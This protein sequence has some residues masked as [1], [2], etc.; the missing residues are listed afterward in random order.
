MI[1]D[2]FEEFF[3][4][5]WGYEPFPWQSALMRRVA[6]T[7]W[8]EILDVPTSAGKTAAIDIALF[9]LTLE[10]NRPP[11]E[12]KAPVR[13]VFTIDRRLVVDDAY[14]RACDIQE[15][16]A[17]AEPGTILTNVADSLRNISGSAP[18]QVIRLR[19]GVPRER[20]F[21]DNPLQPTIVLSTVDQVGSRLL[22]RG[23]GV[24]QSMRPVHAALMGMDS[25]IILDEAHLSQPFE[26]TLA[27]VKRYQSEAWAEIT[28]GRPTTMI[29]MTATPSEST[30]KLLQAGDWVH[31]VLGPRLTRSKPAKLLS[32][33]GKKEEPESTRQI[34]AKTLIAQAISLMPTNKASSVV[35][36]VVNRV[37]TA[38]QV[39][40]LLSSAKGD[41]D[42]IL[43][44]GRTRPLD[45]D[46]LV[47]KYLDR[48]KAGR[49]EGSNLRSLYVIATQTIE[50]GA[51][52]DF[53][54]LVTESAALDALRQRFGRLNR[55]GKHE[56]ADAVIV[57]VDYGRS[58]N[59]D[60]IYG[61]ALTATWKWM[62]Q[63]AGKKKSI[64][65]G[66]QAMK[67]L[68]QDED[69][70][71]MLTPRKQASVL[72][73]AHI[74]MFVQTNPAPAVVPEIAPYL[75]GPATEA[76]DVQLIWRADLPA[77]PKN[78]SA[79][80]EI[81]SALP[82]ASLEV[83]ALPVRS[84]RAFLAGTEQ[85]DLSD[86]EG[87]EH[88][89]DNNIREICKRYAVLWRGE[90]PE[91]IRDPMKI[92]PGD[93]IMIPATYGGLDEFGWDPESELPAVDI[94]DEA[95]SLQHGKLQL[96]IHADLMSTWF[97]DQE[98]K[99]EAA[100]ILKRSLKR[101]DTEDVDLPELCDSLIEDLLKLPINADIREKLTELKTNR[102]VVP[103]P[104]GILIKKVLQ[105]KARFGHEVLLAD[106]C[107]GVS[108]LSKNFA[109]GCGLPNELVINE[110]L[111]G[112]MHDLGKADPRFQLSLYEANSLVM[113]KANKLLA[114]SINPTDLTTT[115]KYRN[116]SGYPVGARHECYSVA[117]IESN[118]QV[119][120]ESNNKDLTL[121]LIGTHHGKGRPL[122]P[123]IDDPGTTI[124]CEFDNMPINF[125]GQHGLEQLDS[126]WAD[127]FWKLNRRYGY[128]GLAYLEML[129]RLADH[130]QS[131]QEEVTG[132]DL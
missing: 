70:T 40:E 84:A 128:W 55:L 7:G 121:H 73:P 8:P 50:V 67:A 13:I 30:E 20:V 53:D 88:T 43:L 28:I 80:I 54:A 99:K 110:A 11:C 59:T 49:T 18:L 32:I 108:E 31:P 89:G 131:A 9:H 114:K 48:M 14:R 37:A 33:P 127:Q 120:N 117:L 68:L 66:I 95:A 46:A 41:A 92:K 130:S 112:N 100:Q 29:R 98:Y 71:E 79:I 96:R 85:E 106:H 103:Y 60:P 116:D 125:S 57:H 47:K 51:D 107:R 6:E 17:R 132:D 123:A 82:P 118:G 12:R 90:D 3:E 109:I 38:R 19:G 26:E 27:W 56:C 87:G 65:F 129:L 97:E 23:Y 2:D 72:L 86:V 122:M 63:K 126:G 64:D 16:L 124:N 21:I 34:L 83:L 24:S 39:F 1:V 45:R 5:L 10:A 94:G 61:D 4:A 76:E 44:I 22:F 15:K 113:L 36:V 91:I 119:L 58:K 104:E 35:G 93:R 78:D 77:E 25:L 105:T 42:A 74:D 75:H 69:K 111:A 115:K 102:I 101:F 62:T 81:A 52:L